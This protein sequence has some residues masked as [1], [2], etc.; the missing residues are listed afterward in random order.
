MLILVLIVAGLAPHD[1]LGQS[2]RFYYEEFPVN[3]GA[4]GYITGLA[5]HPTSPGVFYC[6]TDVGGAYR[7][8]S[9]TEIPEK[10]W[11]H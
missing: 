8:D 6:R 1:L 9:T 7:W 5:L 2:R 4:G 10:D 11:N 3:I